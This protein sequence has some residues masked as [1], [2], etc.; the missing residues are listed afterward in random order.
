MINSLTSWPLIIGLFHHINQRQQEEKQ[1]S[2]AVKHV[3]FCPLMSYFSTLIWSFL[4]SITAAIWLS[5]TSF[6]RLSEADFISPNKHSFNWNVMQAKTFPGAVL[7][8]KCYLLMFIPEFMQWP[9]YNITSWVIATM[10]L[11]WAHLSFQSACLRWTLFE[12][13]LGGVVLCLCMFI[14]CTFCLYCV[15]ICARQRF[16]ECWSGWS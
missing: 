5:S 11:T 15:V 6:T 10:L 8:K 2:V 1:E 14:Y 12:L 9:E 16:T 4:K 3:V 7:T 13:A